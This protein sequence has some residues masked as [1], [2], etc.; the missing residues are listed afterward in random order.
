MSRIYPEPTPGEDRLGEYIEAAI[1]ALLSNR[2]DAALRY[3]TRGMG[4]HKF[5]H[6]FSGVA[7][8]AYFDF[9]DDEAIWDAL[10]A[11]LRRVIAAHQAGES[12]DA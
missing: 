1:H 8:K 7:D 4:E 12:G 3:L 9:T 11:N 2:P 5:L 10:S 6:L